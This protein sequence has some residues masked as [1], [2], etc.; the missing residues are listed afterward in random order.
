M[1]IK[2]QENITSLLRN[3]IEAQRDVQIAFLYSRQGLLM[4]RYGRVDIDGKD[5]EEVDD[6][7]GALTALV[8]NLLEKVGM[9]YNINQFG[10]GSFETSDH[11]I[12]FMEAG[13]EAILL[14]VCEYQTNLNKL[15]PISYLVA[16]KIAQ[17]LEGS[18]DFRY[19]TLEIPVLNIRDDFSLGLDHHDVS[20]ESKG[21]LFDGV[22]MK[23]HIK[24]AETERKKSFKL[25]VLGSAAVGKTS[26]VNRFLK[27]EQF[28]D[29]RPTLGISISTQ[30]CYVQGFKDDVINFLIY[31]LAGQDFFKRVR[32]EYYRGANCA[33]IVY[34]ITRRQTFD[35]GVDFWFQDCR[36]EMGTIPFVLIGNKLDLEDQRE[37]SREDGIKKAEEL[38]CFFTET[39]ALKNL[40]VQDT[41]KLIGIGLFFKALESSDEE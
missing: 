29:Y 11:R 1:V 21:P 22:Y 39:S 34:D 5:D 17:L 16:E 27:K 8:E 7:H 33:F 15:F 10:T 12:I 24:K 31:D 23:H 13:P 19:N 28:Q 30:K 4:A 41:F 2:K 18:F 36:K 38:N 20:A 6:I 35:E 32:H 3:F 25:I 14:C 40:N 37:V 26:L 9:E